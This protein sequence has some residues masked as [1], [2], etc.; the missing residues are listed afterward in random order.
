MIHIHEEDVPL[1]TGVDSKLVRM[2][3]VLGADI[4]TT[5]HNLSSVADVQGIDVL[6]I[7]ELAAALRS[8]FAAGESLR[9]RLVKEGKEPGQAIGYSDDG[10]MVVVSAAAGRI[11]Q[12]VQVE[13]KSVLQTQSGRMAFAD[14]KG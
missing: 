5:D 6:N 14:L 11:G 7:H 9:I 13:I 12:D 1:S 10:S 4:C 8:S 3:K 2:A